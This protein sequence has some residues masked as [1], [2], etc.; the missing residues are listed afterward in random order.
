MALQEYECPSC[1]GAMEFD[2]VSQKLKCPFCDSVFDVKDYVANHNSNSQG[3][4]VED[5]SDT[6]QGSEPLYV[7]SCGSCGGEILATESLGSMKCPF[8]SNNVV[9]KEVFTGT[10]KPDCIIPF[11]HTREE[12]IDNYKKHVKSKKLVPKFFLDQNHID[13]IKA[14]YVPFWLFN[15]TVDYDAH[16]ECTK[17]RTWSDSRYNYHETKYYEVQRTGS[18]NFENVPVDGSREMPDDLMES[19]EPFDFRELVP[20]N[21]GYLAGFLANK[22]NVS[23]DESKPRAVARIKSSVPADF[24]NTVSGYSTVHTLM[25]HMDFTKESYKYALYPVYVLN[26]TWNG[27]NYLFAMNG[28]SGKFVGNL[29]FSMAEA[30]KRYIPIALILWFVFF[31]IYYAMF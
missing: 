3:Q 11:K 1:G 27:E 31:V 2:P 23:V 13:E 22:Y 9:V 7:Y 25:E 24:R 8:C 17:S 5:G 10:F 15:A 29:P 19:L 14:V 12:A 20:F 26:T 6:Q 4:V 18:E 16:Y 30:V 21:M 28:Q